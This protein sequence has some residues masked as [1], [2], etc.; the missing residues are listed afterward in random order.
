MTTAKTKVSTEEVADFVDYEAELADAHRLQEW[1]DLWNQDRALYLVPYAG[2]EEGRLQVAIIR[3]DYSQ[4]CQRIQ[5]LGSGSA[6]AQ[7]P[8]SRLCRVMGRIKTR[9]GEDG[10]V[11]AS[12]KFVC[13]ES[14]PDREV[15]WAG[16]AIHTVAP[17][18]DG[19]LELWR[20][21]VRLVNSQKEIPPLAFLI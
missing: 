19:G 6:H 3:D 9:D 16:T 21:E 4:L 5:R 14:R 13:V 11:V 8:W 17:K 1:L 2:E 15:L 20:K 18:S 10:S 7:E 12:S